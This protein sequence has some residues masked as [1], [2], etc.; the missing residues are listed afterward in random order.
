MKKYKEEKQTQEVWNGEKLSSA[1][2]EIKLL[3]TPE[4][5]EKYIKKYGINE[6]RLKLIKKRC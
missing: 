4:L 3:T 2:A 1:S 5:V 6:N